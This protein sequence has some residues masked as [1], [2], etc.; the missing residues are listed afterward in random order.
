[1]FVVAVQFTIKPE[2]ATAFRERVLKQASDSLANE[3]ACQQFEVSVDPEAENQ[4]FLYEIYDDAAAFDQHRA[5]D[6]FADFSA[7]VGPWVES[8][9]LKTWHRIS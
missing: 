5:A 2:F 7:S 4:F 9:S 1:M 6:Y 8:K 3:E